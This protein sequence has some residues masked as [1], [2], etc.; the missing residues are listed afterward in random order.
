MLFRLEVRQIFTTTQ[1]QNHSNR[2]QWHIQRDFSGPWQ[3]RPRLKANKI[4]LKSQR[5]L[6]KIIQMLAVRSLD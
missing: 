2:G 1:A 5:N 4:F 6:R 3:V